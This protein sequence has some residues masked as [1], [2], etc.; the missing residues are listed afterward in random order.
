M[1]RKYWINTVSHDHVLAGVDGG[2]TQA[3]H[4]KATNLKKLSQGDLIVFYSPRTRF[5]GGEP[6]QKFTAIGRIV[7][8]EPYQVE[9]SPSFHPWRRRVN[10]LPSEHASIRPLI[11]ELAFIR[12][13]RR[14]GYPFRHGLFDVERVDFERIAEAMGVRLEAEE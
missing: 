9:M 2:F 5:R 3:N 10:F 4:G 1:S 11:D 7:D 14:W 12:D 6:L 13:K 8:T